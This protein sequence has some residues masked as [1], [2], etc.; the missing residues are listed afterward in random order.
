M[1]KFVLTASMLLSSSQAF[2]Q[3]DKKTDEYCRK[4]H[5]ERGS[6]LDLV[7]PAVIDESLTEFTKAAMEKKRTLEEVR[8]EALKKKIKMSGAEIAQYRRDFYNTYCQSVIEAQKEYDKIPPE[9]RYCNSLA[10]IA[11]QADRYRTNPIN[12]RNNYG[13]LR[14]LSAAVYKDITTEALENKLSFEDYAKKVSTTSKAKGR[15]IVLSDF[16]KAQYTAE[17]YQKYCVTEATALTRPKT[18]VSS[19]A[20]TKQNAELNLPTFSPIEAS[21]ASSMGAK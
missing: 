7:P 5:D 17:F 20:S 10:P 9:V 6:F 11:D 15:E 8:N 4:L 1:I 21:S 19:G 3:Q 14:D 18:T 13:E 12:I 16:A 2:A